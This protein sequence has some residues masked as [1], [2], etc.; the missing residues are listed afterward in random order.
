MRRS[1]T[2]KTVKNDSRLTTDLRKRQAGR[3][4][5]GSLSRQGTGAERRQRRSVADLEWQLIPSC[6]L[7]G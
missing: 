5:G 6:A 4:S 7:I 2:G 3:G 1:K